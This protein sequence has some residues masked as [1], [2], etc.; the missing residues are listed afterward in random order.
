PSSELRLAGLRERAVIVYPAGHS[1]VSKGNLKLMVN[2]YDTRAKIAKV[3]CEVG[4]RKTSLKPAGRWSWVG[5]MRVDSQSLIPRKITAK[6][7]DRSGRTWTA[8]S[9]FQVV[10]NVPSITTGEDWLQFH[11]DYNHLGSSKDRVKPPLT[12]AWAGYTGGFIGLSSPVV[13]SGLVFI[14]TNDHGDLKDCG[15]SAFD[16]KT[17]KLRWRFKTDSAIKNSVAFYKGR[18]FAISVAGYLYALDAQTGK[19]LWK[20]GLKAENERWEIS[21]PVVFEDVVYAG[22]T[23]YLAA[24]KIDDGARLWEAELGGQDWWPSCPLTPII[25]NNQVIITSRIGAFCIDQKTGQKIWELDG[26]FR[27]CSA[28]DDY[29]YAVRN[30]LLVAINPINGKI[31]WEGT[32]KLG[33]S[34]S[35]PAVSGETVVIGDADGKICAFSSRDGKLL[36][37]FQTGTSISTLQPYKRGGSDVNS[38]PAIS[39]DTVYIGASDGNLY[40]LSIKTGEKLWSHNIGVPIASS[41]AISGNAVYI[42][43][44]DGN[45]YAFVGL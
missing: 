10:D 32:E 11:G 15:V 39:G 35:A 9:E 3:E 7:A 14:G 4:G 44:Y 40:A 28:V 38:S 33:D 12:L 34:A 24:F 42:G 18:V 6:V 1:R 22:G 37:V 29:I 19:L 5:E 2:A 16:A 20:Q 25:S 36:W 23:T 17:G 41:P 13:A 45:V 30:G 31:V 26:G 21:S 27:G 43:A 8:E